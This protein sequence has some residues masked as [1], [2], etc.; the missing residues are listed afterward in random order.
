MRCFRHLSRRTRIF[1]HYIR[2]FPGTSTGLLNPAAAD[3]FLKAPAR[4][5][6][7]HQQLLFR[8]AKHGNA[9][10]PGFRAENV[11]RLIGRNKELL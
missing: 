6:D 4:F 10:S 8:N 1:T 5:T 11:R 9:V 7:E 2:F 3:M